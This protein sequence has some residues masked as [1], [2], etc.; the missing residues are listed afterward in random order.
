MRR[1]APVIK[2]VFPLYLLLELF[3][4]V[5]LTLHESSPYRCNLKGKTYPLCVRG[6]VLE[7]RYQFTGLPLT[8]VNDRRTRGV[9]QHK[10]ACKHSLMQF[11]SRRHRAVNLRLHPTPNHTFGV[12]V[13]FALGNRSSPRSIL[14]D[15]RVENELCVTVETSTIV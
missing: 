5:D 10:V 3:S 1:S 13:R 11:V 8:P 2:S 15:R 6:L 4:T 14:V 7:E 12:R 9:A